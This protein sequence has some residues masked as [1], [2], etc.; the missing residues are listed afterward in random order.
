MPKLTPEARANISSTNPG[1]ILMRSGACKD[2][3]FVFKP[4]SVTEL[5]AFLSALNGEDGTEKVYAHRSLAADLCLYPSREAFQAWAKAQ[6][7]VAH[8][9]GVELVK[10]SGMNAEVQSEVL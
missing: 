7:A 8:A 3:E 4:M 2:D 5:D 10:R 6:P 1:A 9:F